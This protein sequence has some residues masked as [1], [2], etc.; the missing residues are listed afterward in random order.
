MGD[1]T[2]I[3]AASK[4]MSSKRRLPDWVRAKQFATMEARREAAADTHDDFSDAF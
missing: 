2:A 3:K 1:R 4:L